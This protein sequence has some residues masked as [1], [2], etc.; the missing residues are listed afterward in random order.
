MKWQ[1]ALT[2]GGTVLAVIGST[3]W[4][5]FEREG[6]PQ[7]VDPT[8]VVSDAFDCWEQPA[9]W[10]K[11]LEVADSLSCTLTSFTRSADSLQIFHSTSVPKT[12]PPGWKSQEWRGG[13][14]LGVY[15]AA[16][17]IDPGSM[18]THWQPRSGGRM[19]QTLRADGTVEST[20]EH[21][22]KESRAERLVT[23]IG[24]GVPN[25]NPS[26]PQSWALWYR[27]I[28]ESGNIE[29]AAVGAYPTGE[30][31]IPDSLRWLVH[32]SWLN[33]SV[34]G[35]R[36]RAFAGVDSLA[37]VQQCGSWERGV[38]Y[39]PAN[40]AESAWS[41]LPEY[42]RR[43][44]QNSAP[45]H[46]AEKS[47]R[48]TKT[49]Q[50]LVDG[51]LIWTIQDRVDDDT[52]PGPVI[53]SVIA[54]HAAPTTVKPGLL[55]YARNHRSGERMEL[56]KV[57]NRVVAKENGREVWSIEIDADVFPQVWEIDLYR[58][59]KYQVA[60]GAGKRFHV[61]DILGREVKG[62]PKRWTTGF[63]AFAV[64]DYDKTRQFRFLMAEPNGQVFNFRKEGERTPGWKFEAQRGRYI[65]SLSHLRLGPLDYIFA[66]QDD[67]SVRILSRTGEDRFLTPVRVPVG[68][69]LAF[70][71]GKDLPSST[72]LYV[73]G[74]GWVQERTIG[75]DEPVGLSGMTRGVAVQVRD[76]TGDGVP[77]VVVTTAG[78][79]ELWDSA[80]QRIAN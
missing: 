17:E 73:D 65:I 5:Y 62:F 48:Q 28:A 75:S 34:D 58:N 63:S 35:I 40:D 67:G 37:A 29:L 16:W 53:E 69:R 38:W 41:H 6:E 19:V 44:E 64:F 14:I 57:E 77:E 42:G 20:F 47:Q 59:G 11:G 68:Q 39:I 2:M 4:V 7:F 23:Q 18:A 12:L 51:R 79:E 22:V 60:I 43:E 74:E 46:F 26:L 55:G 9:N 32:S 72:V 49:G 56:V 33:C 1:R 25:G 27:Q 13:W 36:L 66:G 30:T 21:Q 71:L 10:P 54:A 3:F 80:N 8:D 52:G 24:G 45:F 50:A 61:I 76:R 78:G 70:R 31:Y 15:I